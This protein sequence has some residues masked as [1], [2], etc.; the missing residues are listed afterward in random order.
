MEFQHIHERLP[1]RIYYDPYVF[2]FYR[3]EKS[4]VCILRDSRRDIARDDQHISAFQLLQLFGKHL[5]I[6]FISDRALTVYLR[7]FSG[8]DLDIDPRDPL[9]GIDEICF[10]PTI[11][12]AV[13]KSLP[14]ESVRKTES[15]AFHPQFLED[16]RNVDPFTSEKIF[17]SARAVRHPAPE[18]V[19]MDH[20]ID[21]RAYRDSVDHLTL[22]PL[23]PRTSCKD[24]CQVCSL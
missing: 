20:I 15:Y 5:Q 2:V 16:L 21:S 12:Q 14:G 10:Y 6:I 8:F 18:L 9:S 3:F 19:Q 4:A 13:F 11:M 24:H 22:P 17:F 23:R 1:V 7:L